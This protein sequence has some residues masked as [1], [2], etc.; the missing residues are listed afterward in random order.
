V[1]QNHL[2]LEGVAR[3]DSSGASSLSRVNIPRC[4]GC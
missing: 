3:C 4:V 1:I 2:N